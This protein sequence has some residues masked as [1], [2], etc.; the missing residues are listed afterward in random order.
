MN[1]FIITVYNFFVGKVFLGK[2]RLDVTLIGAIHFLG[3]RIMWQFFNVGVAVSAGDVSVNTFCVHM[4]VNIIIYLFAIFVDPS[5][6]PVFMAHETV[7]FVRGFSP[8][9]GG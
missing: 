6:E 5:D 4:S 2:G 8:K 9:T 3:H 1:A 7:F